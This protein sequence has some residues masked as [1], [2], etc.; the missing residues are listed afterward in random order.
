LNLELG[1]TLSEKNEELLNTLKFENKNRHVFLARKSNRNKGFKIKELAD[2]EYLNEEDINLI[3]NG[4]DEEYISYENF[5][6]LSK[7]HN[8]P[9]EECIEYN[10]RKKI[11][12]LKKKSFLTKQ[13]MDI[14]QWFGYSKMIFE[15]ED[16]IKELKNQFCV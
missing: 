11:E 5:L 4:V 12:N 2:N 1:I 8:F 15:N 7:L 10:R 14:F 13:V 16:F 9:L 3:K 6:D